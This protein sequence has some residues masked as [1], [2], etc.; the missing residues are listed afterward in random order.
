MM[1]TGGMK[2]AQARSF[3]GKLAK[4]YG[5]EKL[6]EALSVTFARNAINPQEFVIAVLKERKNTRPKQGKTYQEKLDDYNEWFKRLQAEDDENR[7]LG[8]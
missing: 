7:R 1:T 4:E 5:N 6:A 8:Q 2:E 3:L